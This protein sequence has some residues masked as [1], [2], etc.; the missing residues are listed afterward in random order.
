[1]HDPTITEYVTE[2][3]RRKMNNRKEKIKSMQFIIIMKI[4]PRQEQ[5]WA[6][7]D[8]QASLRSAVE[9]LQDWCVR[10]KQDRAT[11]ATPYEG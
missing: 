5:P 2:Q 8:S 7:V 3:S 9:T 1:M 6:R 10:R 11:A 4:L